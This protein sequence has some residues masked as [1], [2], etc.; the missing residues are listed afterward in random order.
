ML[1][2]V[3]RRFIVRGRLRLRW[4]DGRVT[5]YQGIEPGPVAAVAITSARTLRGLMFNPAMA[6]GE[7][8]MDGTLLPEEGG[9]YDVLDVLVSN[10][11][12]GG[13]HPVFALRGTINRA[14]CAGYRPPWRRC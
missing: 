9:I 14:P 13:S 6:V 1:D 7:S 12:A 8:Y 3:L 10:V 5:T 2:W 11:M 4:P